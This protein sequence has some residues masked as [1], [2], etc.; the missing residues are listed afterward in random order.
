MVRAGIPRA[1][2]MNP[3]PARRAGRVKVSPI[4]RNKYDGIDV[5]AVP[6]SHDLQ[7]CSA[8]RNI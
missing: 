2:P 1:M 6:I 8:F 5:H 3:F 7:E 4:R